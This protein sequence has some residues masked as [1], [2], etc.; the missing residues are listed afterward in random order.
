MRTKKKEPTLDDLINGWLTPY[1]NTTIEQV[2]KEW[3]GEKN[4]RA[5][6]QKYPVTQEQHDEWYDWVIDL[7]SKHFKYSKKFIKKEFCF[8]YLNCAPNI[9]KEENNG[10]E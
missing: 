6:Y 7:L 1:H 9:I 10:T 5:F 8:M 4:S 3:V 2:E